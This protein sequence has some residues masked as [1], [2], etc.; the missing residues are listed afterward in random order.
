MTARRRS[1]AARRQVRKIWVSWLPSMVELFDLVPADW[2]PPA[3][4]SI[5]RGVKQS[6]W[7]A[8]FITPAGERATARCR[9]VRDRA[10][11]FDV[12][13]QSLGRSWNLT[14]ADLRAGLAEPQA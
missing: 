7:T 14:G 13:E 9:L 8:V 3:H 12:V 11:D 10:G 4:I 1:K 2:T 6:T 5:H